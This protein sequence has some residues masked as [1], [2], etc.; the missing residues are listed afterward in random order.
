MG[1]SSEET[2]GTGAP[3]NQ[4]AHDQSSVEPAEAASVKKIRDQITSAR[5]AKK[6]LDDQ[7][8]DL[9]C[10][11]CSEV[12]REALYIVDRDNIDPY[13]SHLE[14]GNACFSQNLYSNV[15]KYNYW[16]SI[17]DWK[18]ITNEE[19]QNYSPKRMVA[20]GDSDEIGSGT[21]DVTPP[22]DRPPI[23]DAPGPVACPYA[24]PDGAVDPSLCEDAFGTER[25]T[26]KT[27]CV[28]CLRFSRRP[29]GRLSRCL[30]KLAK[31]E[32]QIAV[33]EDRIEDLEY[34]LEDE[35]DYIKENGDPDSRNGGSGSS[36][37]SKL[38]S[39]LG[40]GILSAVVGYA[41]YRFMANREDK[42][43]AS[44][45]KDVL[46]TD[47]IRKA[48]GYPVHGGSSVQAANYT[49]SALLG[50]VGGLGT[51]DLAMSSGYFGC[52]NG[53]GILG[54]LAGSLG[55]G[56]SGGMSSI[57]ASL[58]VGGSDS[59]GGGVITGAGN[60]NGNGYTTDANGMITYTGGGNTGGPT[61]A[62]LQA[63]S[64]YYAGLAASAQQQV[65]RRQSIEAIYQN[66]N[67]QIQV[68]NETFP[69]NVGYG[70]TGGAFNVTGAGNGLGMFLPGGGN[71]TLTGGVQLNV[72]AGLGV[73]GNSVFAPNQQMNNGNP[74][75]NPNVPPSLNNTLPS[76]NIQPL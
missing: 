66:T 22:T 42:R 45:R 51:Y 53:P 34:D 24:R 36:L 37:G 13:F 4:C 7:L 47:E 17:N 32:Q 10:D 8:R 74:Q 26:K 44:D 61:A 52:S 64:E 56:G 5:D 30:T 18:L 46:A 21:P 16:A 2:P 43:V 49:S 62:E 75:F 69:Q 19:L 58:G 38:R 63:Q 68:V 65:A 54:S 59:A 27:K 70:N 14:G 60:G 67:S 41:G 55:G 73:G 12:V 20:G 28:S 48:Q 25:S 76:G 72:N 39:P 23:Q 11:E 57:L 9:D 50:I 33:L 6:K 1:F 71:S 31:L 29:P 3:S 35:I 15:S 40:A